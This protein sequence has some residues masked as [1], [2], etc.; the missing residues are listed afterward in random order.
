MRKLLIPLV[1]SLCVAGT[2]S[3]AEPALDTEEAKTLYALGLAVARNLH[4]FGLT[5]SELAL[6]QA[7]MSDALLGKEPKVDVEEYTPKIQEMAR[8]RMEASAEKEKDASMAFLE[9]MSKEKGAQRTASGLIYIPIK[10]GTGPSP[11][12]TD[13]VRVHYTG[14]LRD[15][16][17]F[18]SSVKRGQPATFPLN[19]VI[20][21][22]TEGL[23]KMKVG[24]KSKL[25]CPADIAYGDRGQGPIKPGATL[26]F[27][28]ELLAIENPEGAG[29]PQGD[30][31][32]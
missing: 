3:A 15:G 32:Q 20:P 6:V 10:E 25:V 13:T 26:V 1:L 29:A 7:G 14:T 30:T 21:C 5:E 27:E 23:Q 18:D 9:Q 11:K 31:P 8:T 12:A 24:G 17:E 2:A 19:G 16:S 4:S 28:V 22:W